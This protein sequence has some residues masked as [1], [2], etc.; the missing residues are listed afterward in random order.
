VRGYDAAADGD[1]LQWVAAG[2]EVALRTLLERHAGWLQLRLQRRCAD[3][4]VVADALQDTF[5]AVWRS[6]R[7]YRGEG[8]VGAWL[9]GI[10]VRRLVSRLRGRPSPEA[11]TDDE[12]GAH[13]PPT[14][15]AEEQLLVAV[16]HGDVGSALRAL[17]PELRRVVQATV[18]DGLTSREAALLL[19]IPTGTV[20]SRVR[21]AKNQLRDHLAAA[22]AG[23]HLGDLGGGFPGVQQGGDR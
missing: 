14:V 13:L 23:G 16:E 18:I 2:D 19:G 17:S 12:L 10:A 11:V 8:D 9:W 21:A 4:D 22:P 1:L 15:S 5:V 6:A 20:K 7:R 3:P